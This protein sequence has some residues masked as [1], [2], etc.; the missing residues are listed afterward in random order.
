MI[1]D[2]NEDI[3]NVLD[4]DEVKGKLSIWVQK[5]DVIKWIRK[6]FANFLRTCRD[7]NEQHVYEQRIQ[8]MC[9]NNR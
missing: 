3:S 5:P 4:L 6:M 8:D 7:E 1:D 9:L 2:D